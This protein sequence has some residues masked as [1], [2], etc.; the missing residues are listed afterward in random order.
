M[1]MQGLQARGANAYVQTHVQSRSPLELVVMLY[2]GALRFLGDA[3]TAIEQNDL[4]RKRTAMSRALAIMSELQSTLNIEQGGEIATQLDSLYTYLNGRMLDA[5][6][7]N[8]VAAL[9]ESAGLL[10]M[11]RSAWAD[12]AANEAAPAAAAAGRP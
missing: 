10:A 6:M 8:D 2:D 7:K 11:L 1:M 4:A 5:S 12:I 9:D 3:R